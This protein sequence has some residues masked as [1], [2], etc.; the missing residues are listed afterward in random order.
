M[1][2]IV[3]QKTRSKMMS[4]IRGKN[5]KPEIVIRKALFSKGF[6]YRLH[7]KKLPGKPDIVLPKYNSVIQINGCFWHGHDCYLF[8]IP[9]S[10]TEFWE[11]KIGRNCQND[12][13]AISEL[14]RMGWRVLTIW[15]CA[16]RGRNKIGLDKVIDLTSDW[17]RQEG[18][19]AHNIRGKK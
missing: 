14:K 18:R 10:N 15:E 9:A 4:G 5:T 19:S 12:K 16:I 13:K 8:K 3:D 6:R 17:I 7:D 1:A 2:D 11:T